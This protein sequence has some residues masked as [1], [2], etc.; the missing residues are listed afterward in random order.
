MKTSFQTEFLRAVAIVVIASLIGLAA[1]TARTPI[2]K[3]LAGKGGIPPTTANKYRGVRIIDN[4]DIHK[5]WPGLKGKPDGENITTTEVKWIDYNEVVSLLDSKGAILIDAREPAFYE[6]GHI[7]G[8]ISWPF[9]EFMEY[10]EKYKDRLSDDKPL[11]VYCEGG[12][13][14]QSNSLA[15]DLKVTGYREIYIYQG[16][17]SEWQAMG[18]PVARGDGD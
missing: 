18:M 2:L 1:N 10:L 13:C 12:N 11:V 16:G 17:F 14:D 9:N 5:G 3:S 7:P 8:A 6:D 4:W 15:E